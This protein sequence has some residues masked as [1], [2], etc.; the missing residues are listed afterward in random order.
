MVFLK[1]KLEIVERQNEVLHKLNEIASISNLSPKETLTEALVIGKE[2]FGLEFGIV[3]HI[4][5][6]EY[7]VEVQSSPPETLHNGQVFALG[8]TYCNTT[9]ELDDVLAITDVVHSKYKG[10][11]CHKEFELVSYI[12]IPIRVNSQV[13]GTI[14]FSSPH[15]RQL[16]YDKI[17]DSFMKLLA[18]WAGS[19]L[20]RQLA[21]DELSLSK[22]RFELIFENNPSGM[23]LVDE[24]SN[25]LMA[26][27]QFCQIIGFSKEDLVAKENV[28][29]RNSEVSLQ[30]FRNDFLNN[31]NN[32]H[33]KIEYKLQRKDGTY[34]WCEFFGSS[35][36][37]DQ[38]N[39][40][41]IWS[42]LDVTTQKELQIQLQ[43]QA[44][45]DFLT[46]VYNRRYFTNRFEEEIAKVHRNKQTTTSLL[47]F[48]LDKFKL[49]NDTLG[50][51]AGDIVLK[52]F[53]KT[54]QSLIRKVDILG[55]VGGEEFALILA[56]TTIDNSLILA[57]RIRENIA[58]QV[59]E[60]DSKEVRITVSIGVTAILSSDKD[61]ISAFK[62]ADKALYLAKESGR[63]N[64]KVIAQ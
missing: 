18:R 60:I 22:E 54:L 14:N 48:D 3:S 64:V 24:D 19:F 50:H 56:N 23:L 4:I 55:R 38:E 58:S 1:N 8:S 63:N 7:T 46:N 26:N 34:I 12:G 62:R 42:V 49:I 59:I 17:D 13:Y 57:D 27:K 52:H 30:I 6:E 41:I 20:E 39:T 35:I 44:T 15:A 31:Q 21:L 9:L 16:E 10:H 2:Y 28:A 61:H 11:P 32:F 53:A 5:G 25:M 47:M 45:T 36:K 37:L 43:E 29:I 40:G 51:S 33:E